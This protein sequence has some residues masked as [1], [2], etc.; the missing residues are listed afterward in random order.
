MTQ[1]VI[2]QDWT[3]SECGCGTR[4]D[5]YSLHLNEDDRKAYIEAYWAQ[6]PNQVPDEYSRPS[7]NPK[8]VNPTPEQYAALATQKMGAALVSDETV[9]YGIRCFK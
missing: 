6:M 9:A 5:G 8:L 2:R 7:G 3:E 1:Q 4:P